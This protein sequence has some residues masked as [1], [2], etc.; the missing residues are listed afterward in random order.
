MIGCAC[1]KSRVP[2]MATYEPPPAS[3]ANAG[4]SGLSLGTDTSVKDVYARGSVLL[5]NRA[6]A[7][8][9]WTEGS[10]SQQ[11][12]SSVM[13]VLEHVDTALFTYRGFS[14]A[15]PSAPGMNDRVAGAGVVAAPSADVHNG[16]LSMHTGSTRVFAAGN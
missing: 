14:A 11:A 15:F 10:F 4:T 2:P 9:T 13:E 6:H 7:G 1:S 5:R 8:R 16:K 12:D 3:V